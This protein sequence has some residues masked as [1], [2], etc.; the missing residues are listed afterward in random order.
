MD[1]YA[2]LGVHA[3]ESN[4]DDLANAFRTLSIDNHPLREQSTGSIPD[5]LKRF[6]AIC[7]AY[8]VLSTPE[9]KAIYDK[10]GAEAL[11]NGLPGKKSQAKKTQGGYTCTGTFDIFYRFFGNRNPFTD[12][13]E[14]I[15]RE[16]ALRAKE[17]IKLAGGLEDIEVI[18]D[19]SIHEFYNGSLKNLNYERT[20]MCP[21]GKSTH[22]VEEQIV[23]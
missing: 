14:L 19:C 2:T 10:Q 5:K 16:Q 8:E 11:K 23:I 21:D 1:Y 12:N 18:V 9:L 3:T 4:Q 20:V 17:A 22:Y 7:E 13:F 15:T 6:N